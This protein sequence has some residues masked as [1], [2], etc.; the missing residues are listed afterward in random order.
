V[1]QEATSS[2]EERQVDDASK[3]P[4]G[5]AGRVMTIIMAVAGVNCGDA[6]EQDPPT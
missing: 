2:S 1:F 4:E 3:Y 5:T 6:L